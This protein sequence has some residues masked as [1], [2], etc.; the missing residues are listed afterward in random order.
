MSLCLS[1]LS[2]F[3]FEVDLVYF[4]CGH[5]TLQFMK[6][7]MVLI[8][9]GAF[10]SYSLVMLHFYLDATIE[11]GNLGTQSQDLHSVFVQGRVGLEK[12]STAAA[13]N[14][15]PQEESNTAA[16]NTDPQE[17]VNFESVF[18]GVRKEKGL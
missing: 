2:N 15:R 17:A 18:N 11:T 6:I 8:V 4:F 9:P 7:K 5:L 3:G 10:F 1:K 13:Q 14:S 16:Q 12:S